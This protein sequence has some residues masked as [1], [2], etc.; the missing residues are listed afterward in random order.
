MP[1]SYSYLHTVE[2]DVTPE[3][4]WAL[5]EDVSTWPS[6]DAQAEKITRDGPFAAGTTGTMK[7]IGQEPLPYRLAK[8]D[9]MREFVDETPVGELVVRVSHLLTP[10]S[11][12]RLR[13]DYSAEIA[14]PEDQVQQ[15]GPMITEDF[16]QTMASLVALAK[17]RSS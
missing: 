13:I 7:F 4:I 16:P 12:G 5:Y 14:G 3:A 9:P 1:T 15:V 6:W 8:V 10:L 11:D 2:A 17:E